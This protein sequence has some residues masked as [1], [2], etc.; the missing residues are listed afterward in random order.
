MCLDRL[1]IF[2]LCAIF[3]QEDQAGFISMFNSL[4]PLPNSKLVPLALKSALLL[5]CLLVINNFSLNGLS[6]FLSYTETTCQS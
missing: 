4:N 1:F 2:N 5:A 6:S 3:S